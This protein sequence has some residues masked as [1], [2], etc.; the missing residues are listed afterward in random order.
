MPFINV[1]ITKGRSQKNERITEKSFILGYEWSKFTIF[2]MLSFM[3]DLWI[4][5]TTAEV[6][7]VLDD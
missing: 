1:I 5:P 7:S 4:N 6:F 3:N 2:F